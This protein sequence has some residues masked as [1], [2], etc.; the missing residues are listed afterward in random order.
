MTRE[1]LWKLHSEADYAREA[2]SR[3]IG[4]LTSAEQETISRVKIAIPGM[5]GVGGNHLLT[6]VRTGFKH[7]HLSDFDRFEPANIN[8]QV[9]ARTSSFGKN[10]LDVMA[11]DALEINPFLHIKKF[12]EGIS[13]SNIDDFLD[14]VEV[15]LDGLDFFNFPVRRLLFNKAREKGA[16]VVTA[17]PMGFS[18]A[19]LIFSPHEGMTFDEYFDVARIRETQDQHLSFAMGLAPR[20][21]HLKYMDLSRVDLNKKAGPSLAIACAICSGMAAT[22]VLRIVLNRGGVKPVPAYFQFDPFSRKYRRGKLFGGNGNPWQRLKIKVLKRILNNRGRNPFPLSPEAPEVSWTSEGLSAAAVDFLLK[23]ATRAP[24]GDNVQPWKFSPSKDNIAFG[25]D[26][27]ADHSFF[28][29]RQTASIISCGAAIQNAAIAAQEIGLNAQ[30]FPT[31]PR[32]GSNFF[33]ELQLR[34]G[35]RNTHP[36]FPSIWKRHTNRKLYRGRQ[37]DS[38]SMKDLVASATEDGF[39][40]LHLITDASSIRSLANWISKVDRIRTEHRDLHEHLYHM[41]RFTP[42]EA[43]ERRDGFPLN[44]LEAGALGNLFLRST[45]SWKVMNLLNKCR[46]ARIVP[47]QSYLLTRSASAI[48]LLT[49]PGRQALDFF[50]GGMALE[51]V[52]LTLTRLGLAMQPMASLT[53]FLL[54]W[55]SEG[56]SAFQEKHRKILGKVFDDYQK[57]FPNLNFERDGQVLLFRIGYASPIAC[58]TYRKETNQ[59]I[60]REPRAPNDKYP[61]VAGVKDETPVPQS[62]SRLS[63][64]GEQESSGIP[65][66]L[67]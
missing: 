66:R 61:G 67:Q 56:Q 15:V 63:Y 22:E 50:K 23:A 7:F 19:L 21:T 13:E 65:G 18:S 46:V 12:P 31:D 35:P 28:N 54:R 62:Y 58:P 45:R 24:S 10:K 25:I 8:R 9:G 55:Q 37:I 5:G 4:L 53:L 49:V 43:A 32:A 57:L 39:S 29:F 17:G 52:W 3:N 44:N 14:G 1:T 60:S 47:F 42:E 36:L 48:G 27:E 34:P 6:L 11:R 26:P 59:F 41:I 33:A 40:M 38:D 64:G 2:F 16:F 51:R 20:P 30:I